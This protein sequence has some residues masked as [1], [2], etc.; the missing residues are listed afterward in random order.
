MDSSGH[1][2]DE[3]LYRRIVEDSPAAVVL[4]SNE[5]ATRVL[6]ASPRIE[7][8]SG[9]S[10]DEL[11][12]DPE[13]WLRHID[14]EE[15]EHAV[16][17]WAGAVERRER[18]TAEYR[19]RHRD[20]RWR[21]IRDTS[22]PVQAPDGSVRYRQSFVE[23]ITSERFAEA[24]AERSEARYRAL[25]ERLPVIVY[26]DSD[27]PE[28]R[29]LYVSPNSK[30][31]LGYEPGAF[32]A[33]PKLWFDSMHPD[34]L[35]RVREGW[36][37]S[38]RSRRPFHAEYR[39]LKPDGSEVWVRDHS[40]LIHDDE[41]EPLFWQGILLDV[42][43]EKQAEIAFADSERRYQ[44]LIEQLPA[45]V[46]L[47][48]RRGETS[49]IFVSSPIEQMTGIPAE[50]WMS[51]PGLWERVIH[52][53]DVERVGRSMASANEAGSSL[54]MKYRYLHA[55]GRVV[56]VHDTA[57]PVLGP[58][59]RPLYWLGVVTDVTASKEAEIELARSETR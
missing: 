10:V 1:D 38:I 19:F 12:A 4:L 2:H 23:D 56:W 50:R 16:A 20:G 40:I 26:V 35:P 37:E 32:L 21:W 5:P 53:D 18:L 28:P 45:A 7:A 15:V 49:T 44:A 3:A 13:L 36:A 11:I 51:E 17:E 41:G 52:P 47:D 57:G 39:D 43:A 6:Y 9:F 58:D 25:V 42:T 30:S 48:E 59:G 46:Y 8:I 34:D 14:P 27:E 29:S 54:D 24:Q 55:D 31:I 33:D 22:A